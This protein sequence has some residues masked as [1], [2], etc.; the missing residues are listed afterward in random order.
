MDYVIIAEWEKQEIPLVV[1]MATIN[2]LC[3]R[4]IDNDPGMGSAGYF[5]ETIKHNFGTWLQTGGTGY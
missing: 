5:Q 4:M 2:E 1:V 3:D